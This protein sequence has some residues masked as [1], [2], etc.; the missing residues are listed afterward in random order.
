M[1]PLQIVFLGTAA[2]VPTRDRNLS[3]I[4][5]KYS[6]NWLLFD[7]P[8]GTQRQM[9]AT[10]V[11][12]MKIKYVFISHFHGDHF[13]GLPGLLATM[14][15]H[16]REETLTIF[17][18][19]G[20]EDYIKKAVELSMLQINFQINC[21]QIKSGRILKEDE[22]EIK[23]FKLNH[24]VPCF[25]FVFKEEDKLGEFKRDKVIKLGIPEGP[26]WRKLQKGE[27]IIYGE[28]QIRPEDV[29]DLS[30]AKKGKKISIVF[31]TRANYSY[32]E[33]IKESDILIHEA[34]FTEELKK[35]AIETK[36]STA[37][38]AANIA[39]EAKVRKL[40]LFHISSRYKDPLEIE[41]EAKKMFANSYVAKD[42]LKIEIL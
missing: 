20:V 12:Y 6:G 33:A 15:M 18:P 29:L 23:A 8:E 41:N 19:K 5:L 25:G 38:E 42:L 2:S 14:S 28:K 40:Y 35:R 11:S 3:S 1:K 34:S 39:K 36:H 30:K 9:M 27:N 32:I 17:G 7:C 21:V 37:L 22:Y 31:D 13:L 4:A 24:D 16:G 26:L 10:N